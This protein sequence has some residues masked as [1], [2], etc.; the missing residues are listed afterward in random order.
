MSL[1]AVA[2][3][4]KQEEDVV[5]RCC[6]L[7]CEGDILGVWTVQA[8]NK[9]SGDQKFTTYG[10]PHFP[11]SVKARGRCCVWQRN[12]IGLVTRSTINRQ[13]HAAVTS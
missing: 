6:D 5:C 12:G 7:Q 3:A 9:G 4:S 13:S 11:L 10:N 2:G 8:R 1:T